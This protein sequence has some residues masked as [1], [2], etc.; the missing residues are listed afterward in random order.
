MLKD[1]HKTI[2]RLFKQYEQAGERAYAEKRNVVDRIV[3]ELSVHAVAEEQIFYPVTRETVPAVHDVAL[4]SLEEHHIVKWELAELQRMD[5]RH[6]RFDA[7]V[8][9]LIENV[10]HHVQEEE[11][12]YFPAVRSELGTKILNQVGDAM[13]EAKR[14]APTH[15]HPRSPDTPPGNVVAGA[16]AAVVDRVSDTVSGVAQGTVTAAQDAVDRV[17]G[18]QRTRPTPRGPK[19]TRGIAGTVRGGVDET[20]DRLVATVKKAKESGED[21]AKTTARSASKGASATKSAAEGSDKS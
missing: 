8:K 10:R 2:E 21:T 9:V 12:E 16:V 5:P 17:R 20:L 19:R 14:K 7:K 6:E 4:E 18:K 3:E 1:D 13:V 11:N 15:P